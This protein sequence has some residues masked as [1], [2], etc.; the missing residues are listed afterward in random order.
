MDYEK[1]YTCSEGI[2]RDIMEM[3]CREPEWSAVRIQE[4]EKAIRRL[5]EIEAGLTVGRYAVIEKHGA[6]WGLI[7]EKGFDRKYGWVADLNG[8]KW[9]DLRHVDTVAQCF[10]GSDRRQ[11]IGARFRQIGRSDAL[12]LGEP[13]DRSP[14]YHP[15]ES[16]PPMPRLTAED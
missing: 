15:V 9:Y 5:E 4:G 8:A 3:V 7:Q 16:N 14:Y 10:H 2:K 11:I 13:M 12:F 6:F 1:R